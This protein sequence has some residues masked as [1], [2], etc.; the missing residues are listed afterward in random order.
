L[1][2]QAPPPAGTGA[3]VNLR[4]EL[5]NVTSGAIPA[6]TVLAGGS[7]YPPSRNDVTVTISG[8]DFDPSAPAATPA[9]IV[10][11]TNSLG[12][13]TGITINNFGLGYRSRPTLTI[14]EGG[15]GAVVRLNWSSTVADDSYLLGPSTI[16]AGGSGYLEDLPPDVVVTGL[17]T[18]GEVFSFN[19][20]TS[21]ANGSVAGLDASGIAISSIISAVV[22]GPTRIQ[23][24]GNV[25]AGSIGEISGAIV[26]VSGF[27]YADSPAPTVTV[28]G[29]RGGTGALVTAQVDDHEV[30]GLNVVNRGSGYSTLPNANFPTT[31]QSFTPVSPINLVSGQEKVLDV[32]YGTGRR[33]RVVQ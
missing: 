25:S 31:S 11:S 7:G 12:Q 21:V 16:T 9:Q 1:D 4:L 23:A 20:G 18:E 3:T 6:A 22:V 26:T 2:I 10:A 17:N 15:T 5:Q 29:L 32:Y 30:V 27:C 24:I 28:R 33:S 8:G 13:V 14:G 19:I